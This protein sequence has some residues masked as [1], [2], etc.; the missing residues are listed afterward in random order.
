MNSIQIWGKMLGAGGTVVKIGEAK[1]TKKGE[2]GKGKWISNEANKQRGM[3]V[4]KQEGGE[5]QTIL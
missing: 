5:A 1:K 3:K 4:S 2:K